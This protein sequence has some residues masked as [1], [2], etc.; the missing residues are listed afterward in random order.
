VIVIEGQRGVE[1]DLSGVVLRGAPAGTPLERCDGW[2]IVLRDSQ[3]VHIRGGTLAG[4][5]GCVVAERT[6]GL[7]IEG[8][9]CDGLL[10]HAPALDAAG[11][12]PGGLA[13]PARE[14]PRRMDREL[15]RGDQPERLS[16][17]SCRAAARATARTGSC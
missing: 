16:G 12:G 11:R 4:F 14:R 15:R 8:L 17:A 10:R 6:R 3:D 2:G 7:V 13:L 9:V 1:L 5:R